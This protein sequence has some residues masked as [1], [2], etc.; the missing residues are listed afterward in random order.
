M[1][2]DTVE[3]MT[4]RTQQIVQPVTSTFRQIMERGANIMVEYAHAGTHEEGGNNSGDQVEFFQHMTGNRRGD[5]WCDSAAWTA[6]VKAYA[7]LMGL[8][9][10]RESLLS[11]VGRFGKLYL[12]I[13][14][15]V[16]ATWALAK[17]RGIAYP[18]ATHKPRPGCMVV[19]DFDQEGTVHHIEYY[20]QTDDEDVRLDS[21]EYLTHPGWIK[22]AGGNTGSG[23]GG[24][25]RDGDGVYIR[26]RSTKFVVGYIDP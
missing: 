21:G 8:P 4:L 1:S 18:K 15:L 12:P 13:S 14:G 23:P 11:Y 5:A 6:A 16:S 2:G 22:T 3:P 20:L 25:Q 24:S 7:Q 9:Q 26:H 17:H 10:D 19:Y